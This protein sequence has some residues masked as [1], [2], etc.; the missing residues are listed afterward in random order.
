MD[1]FNN[2]LIKSN[3]SACVKNWSL[4]RRYDINLAGAIVESW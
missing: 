4:P 2:T 1:E 3:R